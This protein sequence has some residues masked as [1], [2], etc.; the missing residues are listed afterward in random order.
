MINKLLNI[1]KDNRL[2]KQ[3]IV[4]SILF[5]V[6]IIGLVMQILF[7]NDIIKPIYFEYFVYLAPTY[8]PIIFFYISLLFSN[9]N[10]NIKKYYWLAIFPTI[11][12]FFLWTNDFHNLFYANYSVKLSETVYGPVLIL[13]AI[14]TYA[15]IIISI[16][17][18]LYASINKSGFFSG[19]T[20]LIILGASAPLITN[21]LGVLKIFSMTVYLTPIMFTIT[22]VCFALAIFKYKALNITPIAF[23]TVINNMSDAFVVISNDGTIVDEN[24]TF[25]KIFGEILE[26]NKAEN[27]LDFLKSYRP[28]VYERLDEAIERSK[29]E[30]KKVVEDYNVN[31]KDKEK[32]FE[33]DIQPI[34]S[35]SNTDYIGTLLLFKDVTQ[36][37]EDIKA[38][39]EKQNIIVKQGQLVSIGELAGGV[40]H[41]INT[42]ISAIKTGILMLN[43]MTSERTDQ[44]KEL[45]MRMDNCATKIINI[46]NSMR[47][48]IRNLG[49]DTNIE[50][51]ISGVLK[52]IKII[53][54]NE[55]SKNKSEVILDIKDDVSIKGDPTKLGQVFTNL[56][57]NAAQA[58]GE[59]KGDKIIITV[60]DDPAG[61]NAIV[62]VQDFA[63]GI[64][65][66]IS[67]FVFKNILTT[68]GIKGTGLGLY[69]VYSVIVGSFKG[70][71][72][73][74]SEMGKGTTFK[75][76]IPKTKDKKD[77]Q[78]KEET[79]VNEETQEDF[80]KE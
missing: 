48:Q 13:Y 4:I 16:V 1:K 67:P 62:Q 14:Y 66:S 27:L 57:V 64:D 25:K 42:P 23:R 76:I 2:K 11:L 17:N 47:N 10:V 63:G 74:D 45:L 36:H 60:E 31:I 51:K 12:L 79:Q 53:T 68:K 52:D 32:F 59:E 75:I 80:K 33:V 58:Y 26:T 46:V 41:D 73:F 29:K 35:K 55:L 40:A 61:N 5:C 56:I 21:I 15:L 43:T 71:I 49:G 69:L 72:S 3:F 6:W 7:S 78:V 38:I 70:D 19:Q 9:E 39:E 30:N 44:E 22:S 8:V 18:M 24:T 50:F 20:A 37:K 77:I 65:Q 34:L 54:Y 28:Q